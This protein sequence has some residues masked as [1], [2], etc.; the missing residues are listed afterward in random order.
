MV[1]QVRA[2]PSPYATITAAIA[3]A[4]PGDT[5]LISPLAGGAVHAGAA[6]TK[7][8]RFKALTED[9][10]GNPVRVYS[11]GGSSSG[12]QLDGSGVM[13]LEGLTFSDSAFSTG[14]NWLTWKFN[15]CVFTGGPLGYGSQASSRLLISN[16]TNT[17]AGSRTFWLNGYDGWSLQVSKWRGANAISIYT[18]G[19]APSPLSI[20]AVTT[21]TVGYGAGFGS[22]LCNT[23]T[24][25][26]D[27]RAY[28][29]YG[30][31]ILPA[32]V[33][34]STTQ[35]R[36]YKEAGGVIETAPWATGTPN[37]V[38]GEWSWP[39]LPT[40][41]RYWVQ[42]VPPAGF[43]PQIDGPFVPGLA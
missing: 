29:V 23:G 9:P 13:L 37:A 33:D 18:G 25:E 35:I 21:E 40:T 17:Y 14:V 8:V 30:Q 6:V 28:Q 26:W 15:R 1:A 39:Y 27:L 5:I 22:W 4:S 3:A 34:R 41:Y 24:G 32:G 36:L 20:D 11:L 19:Q 31:V 7:Q 38:T 43:T 2:V 12:M 16:C 10:I 42:T